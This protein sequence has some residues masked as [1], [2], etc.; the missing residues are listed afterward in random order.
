MKAQIKETIKIKGVSYNVIFTPL[1]NSRRFSPLSPI[2]NGW[3]KTD[4]IMAEF[5]GDKTITI[6][7]YKKELRFSVYQ[8]GCFY[9]Y[10]GKII[11]NE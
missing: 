10:V 4:C 7:E 5:T 9:P 3:E 8:D 1:G 2:P 11:I 6:Y